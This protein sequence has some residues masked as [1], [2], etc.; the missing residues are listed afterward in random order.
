MPLPLL[1][2]GVGAASSLVQTIDGA[3]QRN[4]FQEAIDNFQRQELNNPYKELQVSTLK[5]D[6]QTD[7]NLSTSASAID[8]LQRAGART[9]LSGLPK[10]QENSVLVQ[11]MVSQDLENQ[12]V[13]R[14]QLIAQGE[15][16]IRAIRE[17]RENNAL[18]GLGQ[19]LQTSTQNMYSGLTHL[20]STALAG[21]S[22]MRTTKT[23][24]VP[25]TQ[26][27]RVKEQTPIQTTQLTPV[28]IPQ[29]PVGITTPFQSNLNGLNS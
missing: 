5:A 29:S 19:G 7:Q 16:R 14:Q 28:S 3:I 9:L 21:D 1:A 6:Q 13:R 20:A 12:D 25:A 17:Q 4:K 23:P 11:N 8:T 27:F 2:L 10:V 15:E 26:I 22:L 24:T 18:L